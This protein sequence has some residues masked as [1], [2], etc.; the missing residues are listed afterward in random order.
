MKFVIEAYPN[1]DMSNMSYFLFEFDS[2]LFEALQETISD[3]KIETALSFSVNNMFI[4]NAPYHTIR[5]QFKIKEVEEFKFT[6]DVKDFG[7]TSKHYL[8]DTK[9]FLDNET[10]YFAGKV[11]DITFTSLS[12]NLNNLKSILKN[13]QKINKELVLSGS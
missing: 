8:L 9:V 5:R 1:V 12:F 3:I 11:N 7:I 6:F 4:I 13:Y 2:D 10:F